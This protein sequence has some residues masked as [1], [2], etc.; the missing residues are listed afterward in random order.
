MIDKALF[1]LDGIRGALLFAGACAVV[2][3]LLVLG[4]AA[5]LAHAVVG[6]WA[7]GALETQV[8]WMALFFVCFV[9]RQAVVAGQ[10]SVLGR[11]AAD[12][13]EQ[14]R[15][16][17]MEAI[18]D[19]GPAVHARFG[20][21]SLSAAA[22]DGVEDVRSYLEIIIPKVVSVVIVPF[23]LLTAVFCLD[24]VSGVIALA[25]YPF[26][27][28]YMVMI[29]H[30]AGD[31]AARR[32]GEFQRMA[33]HFVDSLRGIDTLRAFG[34]SREHAGLIYLASERF[35]ELTMKTLRIATLS[36]AV[37]DAFATLALA[38]VAIMLG[39]RLVDGSLAFL[40]AL[41][42]LIV[43]PEYFRPI[44]EFAADYHASLDG[45]T[46]LAAADE[47]IRE[48][49]RVRAGGEDALRRKACVASTDAC[50]PAGFDGGR[51]GCG[52]R[53]DASAVALGGSEDG[54]CASRGGRAPSL[55]FDDV[56]FS[57]P[58]RADALRCVSFSVEG[59]LKVAIIGASGS[60]KSTLLNLIGGFADPSS[61]TVAACGDSFATLRGTSWQRHAAYLPQD[62]YLFH[63]SLRD[64][65]AF[66][67]PDAT[68]DQVSRAVARAGLSEVART[69]PQGMDTVIGSG[70]RE[71]SG[72]QAQRVALA[73]AVADESRDVLLFDEPTAHLDIETEL[74]LK[75]S[76]LALMEGKLVFFA[77]HRLH[78]VADMDY[79]LEVEDGCVAWQGSSRQ[80]CERHGVPQRAGS[81]DARADAQRTAS[82]DVR[83][84]GRVDARARGAG[85]AR[86]AREAECACAMQGATRA[87][88][89]GTSPTPLEDSF[90][91]K[92]L[93][94]GVPPASG[95][96]APSALAAEPPQ[97]AKAERPLTSDMEASP[98]SGPS[99]SAASLHGVAAYLRKVWADD[100]WVRPFFA[101]HARTLAFALALGLA[102]YLFAGALMFTSGY[103]ISLA[104][105]LP[106]TVLALHVPSL[107]VRI[108]GLGKPILQY[109]ERLRSHDWAL[110]MTSELR[111]RLYEAFERMPRLTRARHGE[112]EALSLLTEDVGRIQNL[113]LRTLFPLAAAALL[114]LVVVAL[115]AVLSVQVA[116]AM[117]VLLIASLVVVPAFSLVRCMPLLEQRKRAK[118]ALYEELADDVLGIADWVFSGRRAQYVARHEAL[119]QHLRKADERITRFGRLRDVGVQALFG[120]CV[121]LLLMW[122]AGAFGASGACATDAAAALGAFGTENA[123]AYPPNWVAAFALCF[124]PLTEAFSAV[125][126]AAAGLATYGDSVERLNRLTRNEAA[127]GELG[128]SGERD[129]DAADGSRVASDEEACGIYPGVGTSVELR[130]VCFSYAIGAPEVLCGLTLCI[131][132]GQK[133]AVLGRSGAGKS[134]LSLLM[135][136]ECH[137]R[138]GSVLVGG[139]DVA[140]FGEGIAHV[141]GVIEQSPHVFNQ[142]LR[143]NLLIGRADASDEELWDVLGKVGLGEVARRLPQGLDTMVDEGARRFSGGERHR[144][145]LARVLLSQAAVVILDE[146]FAGLDPKTEGELIA[147]IFDT[148][149]DRT[150]I[151][152]T[153]HLQGVSVCDRVVFVEDGAVALDGA[154]SEL[155]RT[156]ERYRQLLSLDVGSAKAC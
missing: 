79:V 94:S 42:V 2:R 58:D 154:P 65:V 101:R 54:A 61:G 19:L 132:A 49:R 138:S 115:L 72:G 130:D 122:A 106:L 99:V 150:V 52:V 69:L 120:L 81:V 33:N 89:F 105:A 41:T 114:A 127:G 15:V 73:R 86:V 117:A 118:S 18:F 53:G 28:L 104:A 87:A 34:R 144:V 11:Y 151:M 56:S 140:A 45:K 9:A 16:S 156:S 85:Q 155:E 100:M 24:W 64:N 111:R 98:A 25:C 139:R 60:G 107:F 67:C 30:T 125:S 80:W 83:H 71:L 147:T 77:T 136:G 129:G 141:V 70:A 126:E 74:E 12:R 121:L 153:H 62:P 14:L 31:D 128:R 36:S 95:A 108:F 131:P 143:E 113:Y 103:M 84:V 20:S 29:G 90:G 1:A 91:R 39:F 26:I 47:V 21:A 6:I 55:S 112:G 22:I 119:A 82:D 35:R 63:A 149:A 142:T 23:V 88:V 145:A 146:P 3:A 40:P 59:P 27:I 8:G 76:M 7:G 37:L 50:V 102:A 66:Y 78:W 51:V 10:G 124:L 43:V 97:V 93:D 68:D 135:R 152:I 44:R 110:R 123:P 75:E 13:A 109:L 5:G 148:L 48:A 137:P 32:H 4:Q 92:A 133:V 57:Y 17:L 96:E 116:L 46:A 38:A 134:T